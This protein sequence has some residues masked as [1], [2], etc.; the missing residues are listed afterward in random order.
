MRRWEKIL[1]GI[2]FFW[3][4]CGMICLG[5]RLEPAQVGAWQVPFWL[6]QFVIGCL[7]WGDP[8][9]IGLAVANVH[10]AAVQA[11]GPF[12]ARRFALGA[13]LFGGAIE[14][15]GA[16]TGF[17]FGAYVYTEVLGPRV[18]LLPLA[19][20]LSW[21]LVTAASLLT[22]QRAPV[23]WN[24]WQEAG[25]AAV[26]ATA[27]DGVMEPFAVKIKNYWWWATPE[28]PWQNYASWWVVSFVICAALAPNAAALRQ[29]RD[30]RPPAVLGGIL[31]FFALARWIHG[32]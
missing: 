3:L 29:G 31:S 30:W 9:L 8:V 11:W 5:F 13:M 26:L 16:A 1:L 2:F 6:K 20:P 25:A 24:R 32:V 4:V 14:W 18:G 27:Y 7:R 19:I 15:I 22:V 12:A 28:I 17:P 21:Y 23:S 10:V